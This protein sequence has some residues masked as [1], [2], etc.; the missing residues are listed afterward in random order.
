MA[1][2]WPLSLQQYLSEQNFS[3]TFGD[4]TVRSDMD[5]GPQKVRRRFTRPVD[6]FTGSILVDGAEYDIFYNYYNTSLAG[7]TTPFLLNHPITGVP[8]EF[9]FTGQPKVN[10]IGG[11]Q[12]VIGF[13]FEELP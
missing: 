8:S 3:V 9:R 4:T 5:T 1:V 7:G 6:K 2:A 12:F 11:G 13:E 10:S